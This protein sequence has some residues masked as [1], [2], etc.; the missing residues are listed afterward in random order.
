MTSRMTAYN[1]EQQERIETYNSILRRAAQ[2]LNDVGMPT[3]AEHVLTIAD[4]TK[5]TEFMDM[6][7]QAGI[8]AEREKLAI[9]F[10]VKRKLE[11][12]EDRIAYGIALASVGTGGMTTQGYRVFMG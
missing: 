8:E 12:M 7:I 9:Q 6:A 3:A 2:V 4:E 11:R 1:S 10:A 5:M